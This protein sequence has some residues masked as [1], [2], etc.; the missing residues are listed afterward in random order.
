MLNRKQEDETI[1]K[2]LLS[3]KGKNGE[4]YLGNPT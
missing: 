4:A 1:E 3:K 2:I